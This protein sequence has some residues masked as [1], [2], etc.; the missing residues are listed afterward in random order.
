MSR[1]TKSALAV[2]RENRLLLLRK[3]GLDEFILP[4]GKLE[5]D[6]S[7]VDALER[8]VLEELQCHVKLETLSFIGSFVAPCAGREDVQ[9][10]VFQ[11]HGELDDAP[12]ASAEICELRWVRLDETNGLNLAPSISEQIIPALVE[13]GLYGV[14]SSES[15]DSRSAYTPKR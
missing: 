7:P 10:E 3:R 4:G 13:G 1:M 5:S 14:P 9:I 6:E 12:R 8:E 15:C 11:F 2:V